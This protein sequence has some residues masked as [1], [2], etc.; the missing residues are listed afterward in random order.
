MEIRRNMM[1]SSM[2]M[3]I[4]KLV[5]FSPTK[6][7]KSVCREIVKGIDLENI[8]EIDITTPR[9]REAFL[10]AD[11][12]DLVVIGVPVFAV[13]YTYFAFYINPRLEKK[14]LSQN[15]SDYET[16]YTIRPPRQQSG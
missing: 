4:G 6:T 14:G 9:N 8:Q 11:A 16:L 1:R 10:K 12:D 3:K 2:C 15:D 13:F 7:T 5:Y